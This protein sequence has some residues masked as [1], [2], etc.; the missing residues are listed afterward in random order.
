[1]ISERYRISAVGRAAPA[2]HVFLVVL[3]VVLAAGRLASA[4]QYSIKSGYVN[5]YAGVVSDGDKAR[6]TSLLEELEQRAN[7][8]IR[9]L[10]IPTTGGRDLHDLLMEI[11]RESGLGHKGVDHGVIVGVAVKDRKW[12]FVTG[13]G[14]E[15]TLPDTYLHSI[16]M[17]YLVPGFRRRDYGGGLY[18]GLSAIGHRIAQAEGVALSTPAPVAPRQY[19]TSRRSRGRGRAGMFSCVWSLL[20]L[21][22]IGRIISA[23]RGRGYGRWRGGYSPGGF[24]T[25]MMLGS[26]LN[27]RGRSGWGGGSSFGGGSGFGGFGGGGGGF[28]GGSFGG[29]SFGGGG[30]G[31]SW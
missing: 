3:I 12:E 27:S 16:G 1:M 6:I 28:G 19:T 13:E 17:N 14:I 15:D 10:V 21:I 2:G 30:A 20:L 9:V 11:G 22:I 25:G 8:Q 18:S 7:A 26:M 24:L 29:G 23:S 4:S 31:G 5:D